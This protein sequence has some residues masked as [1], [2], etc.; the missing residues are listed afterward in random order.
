MKNFND[1]IGNQTR[2]LRLVAQC[3]N[4]LRYQQRATSSRS[5]VVNSGKKIKIPDGPLLH[6]ET[7]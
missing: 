3:L 6:R 1:T 5:V 7:I 2:D 4:Q